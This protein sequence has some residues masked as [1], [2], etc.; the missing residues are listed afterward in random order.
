MW[1][2]EGECVCQ[3]QGGRRCVH[4]GGPLQSGSLS[5]AA[6]L[7]IVAC[8]LAPTCG[9]AVSAAASARALPTGIVLSSFP[10]V[11]AAAK[12][13]EWLAQSTL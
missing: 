8:R 11:A 2:Q 10:C 5:G 4:Q 9:L 12:T 13:A 1:G 7:V 6:L 3:R